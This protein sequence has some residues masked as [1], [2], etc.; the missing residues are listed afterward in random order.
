MTHWRPGW[1]EVP[2]ALAEFWAERHL[3]SLTTLRPDGSIHVV[4]VGCTLDLRERCA[5]VITRRGSRK[6]RN[7]SDPGPVAFC[8]VDGGRWATLEGVGVA[9]KDP[10][11]V[12]RAVEC[13]AARYRQPREN[14]E[15]VAIRIEVDRILCS[16]GLLAD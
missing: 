10:A 1:E 4:P 16:A 15:R 6:A 3:G 12:A 14:P 7:L 5:W 8:Q 13:Y 2:G 11:A 9:V